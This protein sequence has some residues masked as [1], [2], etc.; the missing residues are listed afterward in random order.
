MGHFRSLTID[1]QKLCGEFQQRVLRAL[2]EEELMSKEAADHMLS[3]ERAGF[4]AFIGERIEASDTKQ[5]LFV[6]RY[7]P[8]TSSGQERSAPSLMSA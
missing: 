8:S 1:A 7:L 2:V 4:S 5:R 3:W 6:A